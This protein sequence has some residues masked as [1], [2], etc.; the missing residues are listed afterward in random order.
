[1][2]D[3]SHHLIISLTGV[4]IL[5]LPFLCMTTGMCGGGPQQQ[6]QQ[7][8]KMLRWTSAIRTFD[9]MQLQPRFHESFDEVDQTQLSWAAHI[10]ESYRSKYSGPRLTGRKRRMAWEEDAR[11]LARYEAEVEA[12]SVLPAEESPSPKPPRSAPVHHSHHHR[13][14]R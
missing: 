5:S 7:Q 13:R 12:N 8:K 14:H 4:L 10:Q 6:E 3:C 11:A 1:M 9:G 2:C